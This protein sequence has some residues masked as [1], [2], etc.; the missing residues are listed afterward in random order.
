[1][2]FGL[3]V[4]QVGWVTARNLASHFGTIDRLA[5]ASQEEI[6]EVEGVGP[7]RAEAIA[8]WFS[9][10]ENRRL[11]QE[12][13]GLGLTLEAGEAERP[14]EGPLTGS[15]YVITGTLAGYS[16]EEAK[17]ALTALGAKVADSVSKKTTGVVAGE[18]AGS[19]L[20]KAEQLGV[21]VLDEAALEALLKTS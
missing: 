21:P 17:A 7:D 15:T 12:L 3:N 10:D 2:L 14:V 11:V 9:D 19:K 18:S 4:P 16:R 20:A 5:A 13:R 1:V 6:Q 8:E